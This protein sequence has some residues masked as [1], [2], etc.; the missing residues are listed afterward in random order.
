[1]VVW[2]EG[3]RG[4]AERVRVVR[5]GVLEGC[6]RKL[7]RESNINWV[8][9][10]ERE[11]A[12]DLGEAPAVGASGGEG[13]GEEARGSRDWESTSRGRKCAQTWETGGFGARVIQAN[14]RVKHITDAVGQPSN[15]SSRCELSAVMNTFTWE[16]DM[17]GSQRLRLAWS[18]YVYQVKQGYTVRP[19]SKSKQ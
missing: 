16:A 11:G 19:V 15:N 6:W 5:L 17:G 8:K 7:S 14:L 2:K 1:M 12:R 18:P 10:E 9:S 3:H 4:K 13:W